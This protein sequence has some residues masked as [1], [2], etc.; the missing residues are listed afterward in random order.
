[1]NKNYREVKTLNNNKIYLWVYKE[2]KNAISLYKKIGFNIIKETETRFYM[3]YSKESK[4]FK[5][6]MV[7]DN[8]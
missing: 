6:K 8:K 3:I 7:S 2:N 4:N 1:M 5:K